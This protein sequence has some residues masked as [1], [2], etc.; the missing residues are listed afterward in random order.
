MVVLVPTTI[1]ITNDH[2]VKVETPVVKSMTFQLT[3]EESR[4]APNVVMGM[5]PYLIC[6][7][8][9]CLCLCLSDHV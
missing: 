6:Y 4:S 9:I 2:Q 7:Y 1:S 8:F 5:P 3:A